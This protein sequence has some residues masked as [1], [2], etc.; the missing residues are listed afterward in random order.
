[1][2]VQLEHIENYIG[3]KIVA[4]FHRGE[5][6]GVAWPP[7]GSVKHSVSSGSI[8]DV[9]AFLKELIDDLTPEQRVIR[10]QA[11]V[12]KHRSF[13]D[14][15]GVPY[16]HPRSISKMHRANH[17]YMCGAAVNSALDLEC[18]ACDWIVCSNCAACGCGYCA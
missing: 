9:V 12:E 1:M 10:M 2:Q 4:K 18:S 16:L 14:G 5:F 15:Q 17:C 6:R 11:L 8:A 7:V 13:M 3:Y